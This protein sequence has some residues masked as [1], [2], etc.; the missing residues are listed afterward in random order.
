MRRCYIIYPRFLIVNRH[1][2]SA[3]YVGENRRYIFS[4]GS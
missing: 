4:V 2:N 1:D 3:H